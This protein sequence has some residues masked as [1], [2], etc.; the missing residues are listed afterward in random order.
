MDAQEEFERL[1][2]QKS[3]RNWQETADVEELQ[4][5]GLDSQ[6]DSR[7]MNSFY[8]TANAALCR[9]LFE[10]NGSWPDI[11]QAD[12]GDFVL[13]TGNVYDGLQ[14]SCLRNENLVLI[15]PIFIE[16]TR[17]IK[18]KYNEVVLGKIARFHDS[19]EYK[20]FVSWREMLINKLE[21]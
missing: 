4:A 7:P 20:R 12:T 3:L 9:S 8:V 19:C 1:G 15:D 6:L 14:H 18:A 5:S 21:T 2:R 13:V 17:I 10:E 16:Y 11:V